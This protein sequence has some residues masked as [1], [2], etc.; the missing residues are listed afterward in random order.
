MLKRNQKNCGRL[1][2]YNLVKK[3]V[4]FKISSEVFTETL[5][6]F[7]IKMNQLWSIHFEIVNVYHYQMKV[8]RKSKLKRKTSWIFSSLKAEF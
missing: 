7:L 4:E 2:V 3:S 8:F 1:E 5:I 6:N